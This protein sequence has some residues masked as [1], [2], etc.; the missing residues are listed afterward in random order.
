MQF[1]GLVLLIYGAC[2]ISRSV[3]I[4]ITLEE[5]DRFFMGDFSTGDYFPK[6]INY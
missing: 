5:S 6:T 3:L 4:F 1:I 2:L